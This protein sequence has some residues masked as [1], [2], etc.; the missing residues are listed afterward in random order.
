M[1]L[2]PEIHQNQREELQS[3]DF[4]PRILGSMYSDMFTFY[5]QKK[6]EKY[7]SMFDMTKNNQ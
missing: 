7:F 5:L 3:D 1:T 2:N 4:L 6:N